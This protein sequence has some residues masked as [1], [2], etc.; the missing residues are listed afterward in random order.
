[1]SIL[2]ILL[3]LGQGISCGILEIES[4]EGCEHKPMWPPH[5]IEIISYLTVFMICNLANATG[6]GGGGMLVPLLVIVMDFP[7]HNAIP[8]SKSI[9]LGGAIVS[10]IMSIRTRP[11][12]L[13]LKI[14]SILQPT[15]L[16]GTA[17]GVWLNKLFPDWLILML[18]TS[19]LVYVIYKNFTKAFK[20][21]RAETVKIAKIQEIK[22]K[23]QE[24]SGLTSKESTPDESE[25]FKQATFDGFPWK[26]T[27]LITLNYISVLLFALLKGGSG[28]ES[29]IGIEQCSAS[30]WTLA[31]IYTIY[32][33]IMTGFAYFFIAKDLSWSLPKT[34]CYTIISFIGGIGSGMLGLGGGVI[35]GPLM[36]DIGLTP[37]VTAASSSL[38][39][40]FTSSS[41]SLQFYLGNVLDIE[42]AAVMFVISMLAS[43]TGITMVSKLIKKY[44]RPSIIVFILGGVTT[45]SAILLPGYSYYVMSKND[46]FHKVC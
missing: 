21:Y 44:Q 35:I 18:L 37:E 45:L 39:V 46:I 26:S 2:L 17:V 9:I 10:V 6:I 16:L 11:M 41:T 15:T 20:L 22:E 29:I 1:M 4:H 27:I 33:I 31:L 24:S 7:A 19:T 13:D 32:S 5:I 28:M 12:P 36:L 40:M 14:V 43:V 34:I 42:Y 38:I 25:D 8:L 3:L 23:N 30:Y